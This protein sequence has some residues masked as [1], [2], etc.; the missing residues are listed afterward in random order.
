MKSVKKKWKSAK[1]LQKVKENIF[2]LGMGKQV[3]HLTWPRVLWLCLL[4]K[5]VM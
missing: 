5:T 4:C 1:K 2:A 3:A